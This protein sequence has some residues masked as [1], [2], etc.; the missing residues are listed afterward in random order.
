MTAKRRF[1][2]IGSGDA[3]HGGDYTK[4]A[5]CAIEDATHHSSL[6]LLRTLGVDPN[7]MEV[8]VQIGVQNPTK[9]DCDTVKTALSHGKTTVNVA[10]GRLDIF[11][12]ETAEV[13]EIASAAIEVRLAL[14]GSTRA[15]A[16]NPG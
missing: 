14:R 16:G 6:I 15:G 12:V 2:G 9:I 1:L 11:E 13:T 3:L 10:K 8:D 7:T 5:L 4:A